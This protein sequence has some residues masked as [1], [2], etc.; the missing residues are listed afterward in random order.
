MGTEITSS[1]AM[2]SKGNLVSLKPSLSVCMSDCEVV[3]G[4]DCH[5][6]TSSLVLL[7]S[8]EDFLPVEGCPVEL[9]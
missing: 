3:V 8:S 6:R 1:L 2:S 5:D 7:R 4:G 9:E